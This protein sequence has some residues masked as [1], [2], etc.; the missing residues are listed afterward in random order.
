MAVPCI[1]RCGLGGYTGWVYGVGI[2]GGYMGGLYRVPSQ[3]LGEGPGTSVAGPGGPAGAGV[4]G[5]LEPGARTEAVDGPRYHPCGARSVWPR[6]ALPVPGTLE[7]RLLAKGARFDL[8][9]YK[10]S[11]NDEVSPKYV[12]KASLSP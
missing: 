5:F 4:G 7:C 8:H 2:Q 1:Q 3:L 11:Q 10:V 6:P 12:E 9:F